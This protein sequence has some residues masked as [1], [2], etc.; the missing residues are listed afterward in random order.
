MEAK[1]IQKKCPTDGHLSTE[2]VEKSEFDILGSTRISNYLRMGLIFSP[3]KNI[4]FKFED[5]LFETKTLIEVYRMDAFPKGSDI[6]L[7]IALSG[8]SKSNEYEI[9]SEVNSIAELARISGIQRNALYKSIKRLKDGIL[10]FNKDEDIPFFKKTK[11][12]SNLEHSE[13]NLKFILSKYYFGLIKGISPFRNKYYKEYIELFPNRSV[14][15]AIKFFLYFVHITTRRSKKGNPTK[16]IHHKEI[17]NQIFY[18]DY[19]NKNNVNEKILNCFEALKKIGLLID[20]EVIQEGKNII[21]YSITK[22]IH[23]NKLSQKYGE[24]SVSYKR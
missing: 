19:L 16:I 8:I 13:P 3:L 9:Y 18:L 21:G 20:F 4:H 10:L 23:P 24:K 22:G 6:L 7:L 15:N 14:G 17:V 5:S 2:L 11:L 12:I 1:A